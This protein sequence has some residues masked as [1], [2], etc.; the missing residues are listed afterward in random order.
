MAIAL[1][2]ALF[3]SGS[4]EKQGGA[5]AGGV[6]K[7][8]IVFKNTGNPYG[9]KQMGGFKAGIEEQGF[10]AILRAPRSAHG[11]GADPDHRA[12]HL[13][14]GGGHLHR[15]Q[16]QRRAAAGPHQGQGRASRCSRSTRAST[17]QSRMP[18]QPGGLGEDRHHAGRG[19]VRH[20]PAGAVTSPSSPQPAR[21]PTRTSGSTT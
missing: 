19:R 6:A 5:M 7:Y 2:V 18:R 13:S 8:A 14:E 12:A 10:Q 16:R 20:D 3:A 9:D 4:G 21:Q 17:R 15:R 11:R 1:P